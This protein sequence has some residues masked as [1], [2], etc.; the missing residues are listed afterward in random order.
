MGARAQVGQVAATLLRYITSLPNNKHALTELAK[1]LEE[2]HH[3]DGI[4]KI[5]RTKEAFPRKPE[6]DLMI[7]RRENNART[8]PLIAAEV[9][10]VRSTEA[11][12]MS[13]RAPRAEDLWIEPPLNPLLKDDSKLGEVAR[14]NREALTSV[15]GVKDTHP[16]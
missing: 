6:I 13:P 16:C 3:K 4:L 15:L 12:P 5:I 9:K 2:L 11:E 8:P 7:C 1:Y 14:R 10:Y